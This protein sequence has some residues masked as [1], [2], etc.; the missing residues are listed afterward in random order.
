MDE[1]PKAVHDLAAIRDA[2]ASR[3]PAR[4]RFETRVVVEQFAKSKRTL[5]EVYAILASLVEEHFWKSE[6]STHSDYLGKWY[7]VYFVPTKRK[8]GYE[9]KVDVEPGGFVR[10]F[11]FHGT[12]TPKELRDE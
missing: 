2:I 8:Y 4:F 9:V 3:D 6:Q 1:K 7:D 12:N 5:E 10:V 11:S